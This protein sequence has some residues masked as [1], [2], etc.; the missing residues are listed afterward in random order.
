MRARTIAIGDIHGC[1]AALAAVLAAIEPAERDTLVFLGDYVDR[2]PDSRGVIEQVLSLDK[3][4]RVVPLLGNHE[5]M[6]LDAL[7]K[8]AEGGGW[9]QYG[10]SETLA[11]YDW[12]IENIPATHLDFLRGLK[13]YHETA[14]HFFVHANYIADIPLAEQPDYVLFW[15]HLFA[16]LPAPH[17]NGKIAIVG[18]TA[19]RSGEIKDLGHV[20]CI[21]TYCH[22]SGWLTALDVDTGEVW[23]ADKQGRKRG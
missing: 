20:V 12:T 11:S 5:V 22:G 8:G 7:D 13:R 2:G 21:D 23:Q 9:L 10:G 17:E 3:K 19:Q 1:A 16:A 6:F 14:T 18:H 15:E 4:C